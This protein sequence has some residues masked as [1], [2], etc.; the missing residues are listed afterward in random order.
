MPALKRKKMRSLKILEFIIVIAIVL[1]GIIFYHINTAKQSKVEQTE[2]SLYAIKP[3]SYN[4]S[5]QQAIQT[6]FIYELIARTWN[7]QPKQRKWLKK[8]IKALANDTCF[9]IS[10]KQK[11]KIDLE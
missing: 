1:I 8:Y 9:K 7:E 4:W 3:G 2:I 6:T 10:E 11:I 5:K